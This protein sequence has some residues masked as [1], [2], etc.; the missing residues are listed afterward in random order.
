MSVYMAESKRLVRSYHTRYMCDEC[1]AEMKP[2]G[3]CYDMYP[4]L[5]PHKCENGHTANLSDIYPK[6]TY[7]Q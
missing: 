4:P 2:T 3:V 5:Y 1:G 6:I 7:G